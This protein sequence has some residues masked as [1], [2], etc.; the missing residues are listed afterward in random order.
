MSKQ[1]DFNWDNF[2]T[3][4]FGEGYSKAEREQMA[5]MYEG[6]LGEITEKEVIKGT[7][8]G[9]NDKD[10]IINI[11]FKSDGLVPLSEFRDLDGIKPGDTVEVFIEEQENALGQL[12]LSRRKLRSYVHGRTSKMPLSMTT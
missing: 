6:T 10:V 3:K 2:E 9:V 5:A 11:G 7:V 8:V 12:I 1:E 4:G